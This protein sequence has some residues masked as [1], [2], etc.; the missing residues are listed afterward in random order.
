LV[1]T[2]II[3]AADV[4]EV[5]ALFGGSTLDFANLS[6]TPDGRVDFA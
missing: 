1:N 2:P 6:R 5:G 4:E 3:T